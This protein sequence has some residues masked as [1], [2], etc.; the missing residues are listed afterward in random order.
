MSNEAPG[1]PPMARVSQTPQ[2][3]ERRALV[4]SMQALLDPATLQL[5]AVLHGREL[6]LPELAAELGVQ[7][8]FSQG[9]LGRLIFLE[10]VSVRQEDGRLLCGLNGE[11][12]RALNGALQRLSRD[13]FADDKRNAAA[14][15]AEGFSD[16]ERR[17]L[18]SYLKGERLA[19]IPVQHAHLRVVLRWLAGQFE[20]GRRY[21]EREVN[22]L[23]K[24]RHP[25]FATLRRHLIDFRFMERASD[26]YWLLPQ[27]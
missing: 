22:E 1:R 19:E 9:P 5:I 8:S 3:D 6:S 13:L 7:P 16:K 25:D 10:I 20:P 12:L 15:E 23:L 2:L 17:I 21:H 26:H 24:G 18:R 11:R 27:A 4:M 14:D